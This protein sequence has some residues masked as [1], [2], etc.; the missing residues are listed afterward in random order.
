VKQTRYDGTVVH[1]EIREYF[2]YFYRVNDIWFAGL[3]LLSGV[4]LVGLFVGALNQSNIYI[5]I[6]IK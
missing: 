4:H 3:A 5:G 6:D 1:T 2:C